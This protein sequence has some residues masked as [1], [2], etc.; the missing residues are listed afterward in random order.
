[1]DEDVLPAESAW[2]FAHRDSGIQRPAIVRDANGDLHPRI[3][4]TISYGAFLERVPPAAWDKLI[5]RIQGALDDT[6]QE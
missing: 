5:K 6:R 1:M 3:G 4:S 2:E